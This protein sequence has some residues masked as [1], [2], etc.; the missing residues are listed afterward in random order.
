MPELMNE[1]RE[2]A[3]ELHYAFEMRPKQ[4]PHLR[5]RWDRQFRHIT[6]QLIQCLERGRFSFLPRV[7]M[8][9]IWA[10]NKNILLQEGRSVVVRPGRLIRSGTDDASCRP[11]SKRKL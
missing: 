1:V 7:A 4:N 9:A 3:S 5:L 8:G 6:N 2:Y 10:N 11:L